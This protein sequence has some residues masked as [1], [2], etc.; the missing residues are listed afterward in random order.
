MAK[1]LQP[2]R[3]DENVGHHLV[4]WKRIREEL[5]FI[6][7]TSTQKVLSLLPGEA[8]AVV[9]RVSSKEEDDLALVKS[10]LVK[11]YKLSTEEFRSWFD[12]AKKTFKESFV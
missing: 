2:F 5:R 3:V 8:S 12:K 6:K 10:S 11:K 7:Y 4:N 9:V 1:L